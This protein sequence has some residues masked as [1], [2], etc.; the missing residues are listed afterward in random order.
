[1]ERAVGRR[2]VHP[3]VPWH[4]IRALEDGDRLSGGGRTWG[5]HLVSGHSPGHVVL[6]GEGVV[7]AGDHL[8]ANVLPAVHCGPAAPHAC[9]ARQQDGL[10]WAPSVAS[11]LSSMSRFAAGFESAVVLPGHGTAFRGT[12]RPVE[13]VRRYHR[14]R[15]ELVAAKLAQLGE[16]TAW[17]MAL[18]M[19]AG[20]ASIDGVDRRF[21]SGVAEVA[22]RLEAL[23]SA[24]RASFTVDDGTV[25]FAA[26]G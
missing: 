16:A 1:M 9:G 3:P 24:G 21:P 6:V 22:G 15:C 13:R 10:L 5:V 26:L 20:L 4:R 8:L 25:R 23:A 19:Y 14:V 2:P 7:V 17:D 12:A 11:Y 18:E